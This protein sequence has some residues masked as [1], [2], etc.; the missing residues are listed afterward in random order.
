MRER[1]TRRRA[2][3]HA[4]Q[5]PTSAIASSALMRADTALA[6]TVDHGIRHHYLKSTGSSYRT[7]SNDFLRFCFKRGLIPWPVDQVTFCGWLHVS[8]R[9]ILMSSLETYMAGVRDCSILLG[10]G[11]SLSGNEM[12]R[13]SLRFLKRK[14]PA[15][16]RALKMPV[17][18]SVLTRI[19]PLL[20]G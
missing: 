7:A 6:L 20:P 17:T 18:V 9:R 4:N 15:R 5:A 2:P 12:V 19:L 13:R 11:W 14:H 3:P 10:H 8:A 1:H 16:P